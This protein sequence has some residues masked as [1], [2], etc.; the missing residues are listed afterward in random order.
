MFVEKLIDD[1]NFKFSTHFLIET[2]RTVGCGY[3][4]MQLQ[5]DSKR[6]AS[7]EPA[8]W[9]LERRVSQSTALLDERAF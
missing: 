6:S 5:V 1:C 2:V 4:K 8:D 9:S 3:C 7:P